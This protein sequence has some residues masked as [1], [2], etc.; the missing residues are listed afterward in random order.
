LPIDERWNELEPSDWEEFA[1][2]W[3]AELRTTPAD[4]E[5]DLGQ[6]VVMM[7]FTATAEQQWQ[8]L[9]AAVSQAESDDEL[10]HVAA[11]PA[12]HLLGWHGADYIDAVEEQAAADP[13]FARMLSGVWKYLMKD[14]VWERVQALKARYADPADPSNGA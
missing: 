10:K 14:E 1:R 4:P 9:R 8:F 6:S 2:D 13:K 3:L 7:S 5:S 12:E 11:G